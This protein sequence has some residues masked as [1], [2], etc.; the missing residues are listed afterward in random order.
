[1]SGFSHLFT[2]FSIGNVTVKK[3]ELFFF[4]ILMRLAARTGC[5]RKGMRS[6]LPSAPKAERDSSSCTALPVRYPVKCRKKF[7]HGWDPQIVPGLSQYAELVHQH[8][9]KIFGQIN[10]GG[11]TTLQNPPQLLFAPTQMPEPSS[12]FNTKE[13]EIEDIQEV[14]EALPKPLCILRW[15]AS[16]G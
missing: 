2:P 6:I 4:R 1:M 3:I 8:G 7:I 12:P 14:I 13:M 11:H 10:H 9:S 5:R 16:T 15:P